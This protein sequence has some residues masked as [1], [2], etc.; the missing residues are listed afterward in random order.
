M[1]H[2]LS[3]WFSEAELSLSLKYNAKWQQ[4][5]SLHKHTTSLAA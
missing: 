4:Y 3:G 5:V 2:T 1:S